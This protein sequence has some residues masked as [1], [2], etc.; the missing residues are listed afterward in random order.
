M[1]VDLSLVGRGWARSEPDGKRGTWGGSPAAQE[2]AMDLN[3]RSKRE[4]E[5][6]NR[7]WVWA[8]AC[9]FAGAFLV[10]AV[11]R[12]QQS[13]AGSPPDKPVNQSEANRPLDD[14]QQT[15]VQGQQQKNVK[16]ETANSERKRQFTDDSAHLLKLAN[17]LKKE[18]DKTDK[19][20]LSIAVIRKADEIERLA[21]IVKEKMK[22]TVG[23]N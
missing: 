3:H 16:L 1:A 19:D 20:T 2:V 10:T 6:R 14:N 22:V 7:T 23:S 13:P 12:G 4:S 8:A 11:D 9:L 18:V 21:H 17:E 5:P 15:Q